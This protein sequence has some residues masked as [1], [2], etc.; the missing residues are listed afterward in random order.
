MTALKSRLERL[1]EAQGPIP[2]AQF[3]AVCLYDPDHGYYMTREPFGRSGDFT[4]APE[5]SQM[6]GELVGV[7]VATAW[8]TAGRPDNAIIAEIGP[9]RGTLM[10]DI[11]RTLT[12]A[13][14][15]LC[16]TANFVLIE[17]SPALQ[18]TQAETLASAPIDIDW[19]NDVGALPDGP[20]FLVGNELFDAVPIHQYVRT[21][22]VWRERLVGLDNERRLAFVTGPGAIDPALLPPGA[23]QAPE[24]S[25][26]EL[27]PARMALMDKI[28]TRI[29]GQGGAGLFIDYGH[30]VS[31]IGDTL[32]AMRGHAYDGIFA[33]PG[34]AD[35]TSHID[36]EALA[37]QAIS[38]GLATATATQGQFLLSM[39]LLERAG[40]LGNATPAR[41]DEIRAQVERLAAS[42]QM[43]DLFKVLCIAPQGSLP[44]PF[45]VPA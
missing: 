28:A 33:A 32:Q 14:P 37:A 7:W 21:G 45:P 20:L 13:A 5:I 38:H 3:M 1:I 31:G 26:A 40:R 23:D 18:K 17:V 12:K 27:A 16:Q 43:G 34:E 42:G 15:A 6:F 39:G 24:G 19:I 35:L 36:F 10:N 22:G 4:T 2:V 41:Q 30:L 25:I 8:T 29:A 11:A 9:G 44:S